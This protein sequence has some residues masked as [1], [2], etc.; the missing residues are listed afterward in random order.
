MGLEVITP[1]DGTVYVT[2]NYA[3]AAAIET[4][5]MNSQRAQKAWR[6]TTLEQR[7][8]YCRNAL[9]YFK[10]YQ[11]EI[12]EELTW[13]M[14]RPISQVGGEIRGLCERSK[15]MIDIAS[16]CLADRT[17]LR[18]NPNERF[19]TRDPLGCV[20]VIAPWNYPYLTAINTIIPALLAG[21]TVILKHAT[22]TPLCAERFAAAFEF[23]NL[24]QGVFQYLHLTHNN[25]EK[26]IQHS[27]ID[28]VAFTGSVEGGHKIQQA[29]SKRFI[30]VSL[31][32]GGKDPAYV[33]AD[34][35]LENTLD[36]L[37]DGAFFN[38]GQ[39]CC[40][41]ERIYVDKTIY[42]TFLEGFI[43]RTRNYKLGNPTDTDTNLGPVVRV[44]HAAFIQSQIESAKK[45]GAISFSKPSIES[46]L[47]KQYLQ[48][49]VLYNVDHSMRLMQEETFGPAVGIM[50][51]DSDATA[52]ELMN[53]S[54]YGL[55]ASIWTQ[56]RDAG[57]ALGRHIETGTVFI[58]R[59]DYLDPALPWTGV[60]D[61][62]RGY[63]L[64]Q[65][66]FEQLTR[67]KGFNIN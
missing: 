31:E 49:H 26:L 32:L 43:E 54:A 8:N 55:T 22:Q 20:F 19:I 59:C 63:S 29:A 50:A 12:G 15:Y 64:S 18:R 61:T 28:Y 48:P 14:G 67:A 16:D 44:S 17:P 62:G 21:N 58:N 9:D 25:T 23:A 51:V 37:V 38:S 1:V 60:K 5:V 30:P 57:I 27:S 46:K 10:Q 3:D 33:R 4:A 65:L 41:I 53:D 47:G 42:D 40:G 24:P 45:N 34:C 35:D 56:D 11:A 52:L 2:R 66:G 39:S 36:N 7:I 13:Q 6:Q